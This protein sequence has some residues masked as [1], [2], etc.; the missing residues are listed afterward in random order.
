MSDLW[1][2]L[3]VDSRATEG[4]AAAGLV[5]MAISY[6]ASGGPALACLAGTALGAS[7]GL[8]VARGSSQ[9]RRTIALLTCY[10][11]AVSG[12]ALQ[13]TGAEIIASHAM[14]FG[15]AVYVWVYLAIIA[16]ESDRR[17]RGC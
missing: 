5:V 11:M 4:V 9:A 17:R 13:A 15:A 12:I 7:C 16:E 1:R 10:A 8:A 6:W 2:L 3:E 14:I